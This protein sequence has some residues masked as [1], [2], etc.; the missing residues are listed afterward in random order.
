MIVLALSAVLCAG[1]R[2]VAAPDTP[3]ADE[4][5][6]LRWLEAALAEAESIEEAAQ[7]A[8]A[9]GRVA[10]ELARIDPKR[11][12][13]LVESQV[14]THEQSVAMARAAEGLARENRFLGL[15][16]LIRVGDRSAVLEALGR[17][18]A[19]EALEDIEEAVDIAGKIDNLPVRRIVEREVA[20]VVWRDV[21][22]DVR[23]AVRTAVAWADT[24]EDPVTRYE[25]LAYAAEGAA[26]Y[27]L[28]EA[29]Q[30]AGRI[31]AGDSRDLAWRLVI[32]RISDR[33]PGEGLRLLGE[34]HTSLQR[35]LAAT[36]V[37]AGLTH[38]DRKEEAL[39][40]A[41]GVRLSAESD[42][43]DLRDRGLVLARLAV[44]IVDADSAYAL[45]VL[46]D[47]WPPVR[48]YSTQ[49]SL[50]RSD[51][52]PGPDA[53]LEL[54]EDAWVE[55][56]RTDAPL[57]EREIAS[58]ALAAAEDVAQEFIS[59]MVQERPELVQAA[60]P[61]AVAAMAG[62]DPAV[63]LRLADRIE[64]PLVRET[65]KAGIA[66]E[67]SRTRPDLAQEIAGS[68]SLPSAKSAALVALARAA[69]P[70]AV[71]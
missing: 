32:E 29:E 22:S 65:A 23:E 44:A 42:I 5:E 3:K 34:V 54:I 1:P 11:A 26:G 62:A 61:D 66:A 20:R 25:A 50:A 15:A 18:V 13:E 49:C 45:S 10:A 39:R 55:V 16:T 48:R 63:A 36:A 53:Q 67:T 59:T 37:V 56:R 7:R 35:N 17:I 28:Q 40:L 47:V 71:D 27:D 60:L 2:S 19:M 9:V 30:I 70:R 24:L 21:G 46:T 57:I 58:A 8:D 64:D 38:A 12:L 41:R 6:A 31:P 33:Q 68:L 52:H 69:L 51:N 14:A 43:E 4:T